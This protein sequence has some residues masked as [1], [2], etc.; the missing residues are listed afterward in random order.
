MYSLRFKP[1]D[2]FT[3]CISE[4]SETRADGDYYIC[5]EEHEGR[6]LYKKPNTE[7]YIRWFGRGQKWYIDFGKTLFFFSN[8]V[9]VLIIIQNKVGIFF[10][11]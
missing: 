8:R 2:V 3:V 10:S 5:E 6:P 1:P 4:N 11:L 9:Y 7:T